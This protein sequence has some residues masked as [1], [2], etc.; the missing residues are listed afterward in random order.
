MTRLY[1]EIGPVGMNHADEATTDCFV[2][3]G[4]AADGVLNA[5]D[6]RGV[7]VGY[8]YDAMIQPRSPVPG[9]ADGNLIVNMADY[10]VWRANYGS[11]MMLH[12]DH[13]LNGFI[14][15]A[16]YVIWRNNLGLMAGSG[17]AIAIPEPS[18]VVSASIA[19][20]ALWTLCRPSIGRAKLWRP[21]SEG[22]VF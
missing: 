15:G 12:S 13:N 2:I 17:G 20:L 14:D 3:L 18:A 21:P 11:T 19:M 5:H 7:H 22:R 8:H 1:V 4:D 16:D 6:N 9:D 10:G